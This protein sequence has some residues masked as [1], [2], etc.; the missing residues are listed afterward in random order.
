MTPH[1]SLSN[2]LLL[3]SSKIC[4]AL[5]AE[6][7]TVL[8]FSNPLLDALSVEDVLLIA[9]ESCHEVVAKEVAPADGT[10][11][12]Q[13]TH[14]LIQ[15]V[16]VSVAAML[17]PLLGLLVLKFGLVERGDDL[18]HWQ[19]NGKQAA[20]HALNEETL[21]LLLLSLPELLLELLE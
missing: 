8:P 20:K 19:W 13:A 16:V 10:L 3:A 2:L 9:M 14:A 21:S 4:N 12:P 7:A 11:P 18:W 17:F 6:W 1:H 5:T 15:I